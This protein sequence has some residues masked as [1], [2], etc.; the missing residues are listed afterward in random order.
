MHE[1][2]PP[3]AIGQHHDIA[4]ADGDSRVEVTL[5]SGKT[6]V[7]ER[8][9][10][11]GRKRLAF[12][13]THEPGVYRVAIAGKGQEAVKPRP[14]ATFVVNVD[15]AES[16]LQRV[17]N[18]RLAQLTAGG[19]EAKNVRAPRRRVEMWHAMGAALLLLLLGEALLLRRK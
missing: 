9:R 13:E 16:D 11:A 8:D 4:L 12:T 19:A 2:E 18:E 6:R 3:V 5:P 1:A 10:V 7:F 15:A 14:A 17:P